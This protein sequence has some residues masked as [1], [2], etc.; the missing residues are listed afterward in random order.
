MVKKVDVKKEWWDNIFAPSSALAVIT[1]VDGEGRVNAAT[2]GTCTRVCHDPVYISFTCGQ[3]KDTANNVLETGEFTVN[4]VP[5]EQAVLN[6]IVVC[7]LEF[8]T[9]INELERAQLGQLPA[10]VLRPPRVEEC[11]SHFECRVEW[12]QPWATRMM[13]CGKV[14]AVI[15]TVRRELW[16]VERMF[17]HLQG[18]LR[19]GRGSPGGDRLLQISFRAGMRAGML[20]WMDDFAWS[21]HQVLRVDLDVQGGA[22]TALLRVRSAPESYV[23]RMRLWLVRRETGWRPWDFED[24]AG[25]VRATTYMLPFLAHVLEQNT[26]AG[27]KLPDWTGPLEELLVGLEAAGAMDLERAR[28]ALEATEEVEFPRDFQ[29]LRVLLA[30]SLEVAEGRYEEA[31]AQIESASAVELVILHYLAAV[32]HNALGQPEQALERARRYL[33]GVGDDAEGRLEEGLALLALGRQEEA[34]ASFRAGL[35]EDP[36]GLDLLVELGA[37]LPSGEE[38]RRGTSRRFTDV[39][40][41]VAPRTICRG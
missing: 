24:L 9:G 37:A 21:E 40:S 17:E 19:P 33:A 39:P 23:V 1:T 16:D 15:G 26:A 29:D 8:K 10:R 32:A 5:F 6:K 41:A 18:L 7:G 38:D 11:R 30:A 35:Q 28:A 4:L 25:G 13:V 12:T 36:R 14:E 20:D 34:V 22:A 3:G 2:F 31:L 27:T